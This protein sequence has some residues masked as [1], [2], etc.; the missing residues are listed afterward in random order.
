MTNPPS[1]QAVLAGLAIVGL[2]VLGTLMVF[3]PVP[4]S[5]TTLLA[6]IVGAMAGALTVSAGGKIA[7]KITSSSGPNAVVQPDATPPQ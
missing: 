7:D 6:T 3:M 5:N 2:G 1:A 4:G